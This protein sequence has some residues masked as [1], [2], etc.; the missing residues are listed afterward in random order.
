MNNR[1]LHLKK[2]LMIWTHT[3][4]Y[5]I[6]FPFLYEEYELDILIFV[7]FHQIHTEYYFFKTMYTF[8][9]KTPTL[10]LCILT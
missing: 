8:F 9:L 1:L 3:E 7:L 2:N 10:S 6:Q 5:L 4:I